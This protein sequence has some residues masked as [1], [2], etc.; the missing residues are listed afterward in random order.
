MYY[1]LFITGNLSYRKNETNIYQ[2]KHWHIEVRDYL[3]SE[4]NINNKFSISQIN[5][6]AAHIAE[7]AE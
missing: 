3:I 5:C 6:A 4:F 1:I 2:T 7:R